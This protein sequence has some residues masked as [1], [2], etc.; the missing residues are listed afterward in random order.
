MAENDV[1]SALNVGSGLNTTELIKNLIEAERAP[2]ED[3]INEK[4]ETTEVSISAIAELKKTIK[5]SNNVIDDLDGTN[6]FTGNS[7]STAVSLTVDDPAKIKEMVNSITVSKLARGQTLVYDGFSSATSNIGS[8]TL[9]FQRGKWDNGSFTV[10]ATY[11]SQQVIIGDTSYTLNDIKD[12]INQGNIGV[13]ASVIKKTATDYALALRAETGASNS[14]EIKVVEGNNAGLNQLRHAENIANTTVI[15]SASAGATITTSAAHGFQIGDT[16]KYIAAGTALNGLTSLSS[17][18][19]SSV[20]STTFTLTNSDGTS[21]TYGGSHGNAN[22]KFVRTSKET[23]AGQDASITLDGVSITRSKNSIK[24]LIDGATLNLASATTKE[25]NISITAS[26]TKVLEAIEKLIDE[27]NEMNAQMQA[28]LERGLD[29]GEKGA[30]AGDVTVRNILQKLKKITT[31]PIYGYAEKPIFLTNL[32]VS[33]NQDGMLKLNERAFNDAFANSPQDLTALFT[34][35]LHSSSS[36]ITPKLSGSFYEPGRYAFDIGTQGYLTGA[37]PVSTDI[38]TSNFSPSSGSQNLVVTVDGIQ[39]E[40][41]LLTGGPYSTTSALSTAIENAINADNNLAVKQ[42]GVTVRYSNNRYIITSKS[43]GSKSNVVVNSIDAG[44]NNY[45]GI[46]GGSQTNG[47]G[48][49]VGASLTD[50]PLKQESGSFRSISGKAMGLSLKVTAPGSSGFIYIGKSYLSSLSE[51]LNEVLK[52]SGMLS[53]RTDTLNKE[54]RTYNDDL[55]DLDEEIEQ[56]RDRYKQQYGAMEATVNS[57][58]NTGEY[59]T[60][61][62]DAQ[63]QD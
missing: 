31:E 38:T 27:V 43:F 48:S 3:K 23:L 34:D 12:A 32:G 54:L 15:S 17:Y 39:S 6:V 60:S 19:V 16:V 36:L 63:N 8:G 9:I 56:S 26:Q 42:I 13:T 10:D 59:L 58:K 37:S 11:N 44:L 33:T 1:F 2:K 30:L 24:D 21:V 18:K 46:Q 55:I 40:T 7:T 5:D 14:F 49:E 57:L 22:D 25:E 29:G 53:S 61:Y 51:Y 52:P 47:T 28:L 62:M 4:I 45:L 41:I 35:R 50:T 20:G